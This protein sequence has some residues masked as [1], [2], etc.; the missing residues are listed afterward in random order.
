MT[1]ALEHVAIAALFLVCLAQAYLLYRRRPVQWWRR[2]DM[3]PIE[4]LMLERFDALTN[5]LTRVVAGLHEDIDGLRSEIRSMANLPPEAQIPHVVRELRLLRTGALLIG[6]VVLFL[7][8]LVLLEPRSTS[9]ATDP[10]APVVT[11]IWQAPA[12][13]QWL[14]EDWP[15]PQALTCEGPWPLVVERGRGAVRCVEIEPGRERLILDTA[16]QCRAVTWAGEPLE[17]RPCLYLAVIVRPP[18]AQPEA[19]GA[20]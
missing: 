6:V 7:L 20:E 13:S 19:A 14:V 16:G 9:A 12:R 2:L 11:V 17:R 10:G 15:S 5:Q 8:A 3:A 4:R 1:F 18:T